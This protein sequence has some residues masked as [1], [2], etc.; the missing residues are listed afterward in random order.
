MREKVLVV[1]E[2]VDG[3][4]DWSLLVSVGLAWLL[5]T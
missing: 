5:L 4:E 1:V 2:D 3:L